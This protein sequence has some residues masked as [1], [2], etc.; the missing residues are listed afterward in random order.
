MKI[1][2]STIFKMAFTA[3]CVLYVTALFK[4][5]PTPDKDLVKENATLRD[6]LITISNRS[7]EEK[8][9]EKDEKI[10]ELK[11]TIESL[12]QQKQQ[13]IIREKQ[14]PTIVNAYSDPELVSA[15]E[16]WAERYP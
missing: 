1:P 16:E 15:A 9:R 2:W 5:N 8:V 4:K 12:S 13:I 6:S 11:S 7:A 14:V 3:V 10:A